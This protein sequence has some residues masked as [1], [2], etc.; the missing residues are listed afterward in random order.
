MTETEIRQKR[1]EQAWE[2]ARI[3]AEVDKQLLS[4]DAVAAFAELAV[5]ADLQLERELA[6]A[7]LEVERLKADAERLDWLEANGLIGSTLWRGVENLGWLVVGQLE[8]QPTLRQAIDAAL[9]AAATE[10]KCLECKGRKA[11]LSGVCHCGMPMDAGVFAHEGHPATE[12]LGPCFACNNN[13]AAPTGEK[14]GE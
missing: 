2:V 9:P 1:I 14:E 7:L 3:V 4:T 10:P 8:L 12:M 6:E 13:I 11:V 5:Q